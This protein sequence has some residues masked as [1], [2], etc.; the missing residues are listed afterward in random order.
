LNLARRWRGVASVAAAGASALPATLEAQAA[1]PPPDERIVVTASR[2]GEVLD[3]AVAGR[4]AIATRQPSSLLEVLDDLPGVRAFS[5]GGPAGG[6][7]LSIR[8]GEP[9]FTVV[10]LDGVRLN[11]PTNSAGGAFDFALLDPMAVERVEVLRNAASAV[12]GSDALSGVVQVVARAPARG[13]LDMSAQGWIDSRYGGSGS[14]GLTG[15]WGS[16]GVRVSAGHYDSGE[17]DP[18]GTLRRSQA[19]LRGEQRAGDFRIDALAL[20]ARDRGSLYPEDSGGPLLAVNRLME[21]REGTLAVGSIALSRDP[22]ARLRPTVLLAR[23]LQRSDSDV[24]A[25]APG[26][27]GGVPATVAHDRFERIEATAALAGDVGIVT[28]SAGGVVLREQGRSDGT[29]DFGFPL[30]T[31]FERTR[32]TRSGFAEAKARL[33]GGLE[34][35]G[36]IRYDRQGGSGNWTG[37]AGLGWPVD[38]ALRLNAHIATGYKLPSLYALGHPLIGNPSLRPE[39]SRTIDAGMEWKPL[40]GQVSLSLFDTRYRDLI[41]FDPAIFR[42]VNRSRVGARGG[43]VAAALRL[44]RQWALDGNVGYV[45]LSSATPLRGRP[46][47]KAHMRLTWRSG[48][49]AVTA[50]LRG[51]SAFFDNS[52]PTGLQRTSGHVEADAGLRFA[53]SEHLALRLTL[54]NVGDNRSWD[55]IGTPQPGRSLRLAIAFD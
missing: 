26:A 48:P 54:L 17:G 47:W 45:D 53:A 32:V 21:K 7:F 40:W 12:H 4:E 11:D 8:G 2:T 46:E 28:A 30:P 9:N 3:V 31:H 35:D 38:G 36:A 39:R 20:Y 6:S 33:P 43:E 1:P 16:G 25:I 49:W 18:A 50:A 19:L 27:L 23:S 15:G 51:N 34:W 14:A 10:L 55:S 29:L 41:D 37:R 24:P 52:I 22:S 13:G 44:D 5:T 42:L